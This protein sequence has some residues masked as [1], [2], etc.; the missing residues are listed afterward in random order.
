MCAASM[1]AVG[2]SHGFI[3]VF[4]SMQILRWCHEVDVEQSSVSALDF[5]GDCSRL[6]AGYA[7]GN[8]LMFD[9]SDGKV[10]RTMTDVH[11]P[12][13]A[14]LHIKVGDCPVI[15]S[16]PAVRSHKEKTF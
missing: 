7:S 4:D 1:I 12:S 10:L 5:S 8:I 2:T 11:T 6:L 14:V 13:T 9:V 15:C 16:R 3:L